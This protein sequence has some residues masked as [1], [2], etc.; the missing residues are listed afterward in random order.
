MAYGL[1]A[2][3]CHPLK[4]TQVTNMVNIGWEYGG[5]GDW[6]RFL[7]G[8]EVWNIKLVTMATL[9]SRPSGLLLDWSAYRS[10]ILGNNNDSESGLRG[11][12]P[13]CQYPLCVCV[14]GGHRRRNQGGQGGQWPVHFSDWGG[15]APPLFL[16]IL[17]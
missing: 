3:S 8:K 16:T 15:M 12:V 5:G 9:V 4:T 17:F 1:K 2:S 11:G 14:W 13:E 6:L 10:S 7:S